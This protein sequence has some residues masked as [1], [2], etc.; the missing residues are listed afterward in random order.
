MQQSQ[1]QYSGQRRNRWDQ[2]TAE[3]HDVCAL[4]IQ[5]IITRTNRT[6][7]EMVRQLQI[8]GMEAPQQQLELLQRYAH[9]M[10]QNNADQNT[11]C[12]ILRESYIR[13]FGAGVGLEIELLKRAYFY[14]EIICRET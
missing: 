4:A 11:P 6:A 14:C 9:R 5:T 8:L 2:T 10:L 1:Q 12:N 3:Q 7:A 13:A